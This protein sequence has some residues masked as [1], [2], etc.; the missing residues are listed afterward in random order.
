MSITIKSGGLAVMDPSDVRVFTFDWDA[1]NLSTAVTIT[2]SSWTITTTQQNGL[3]VLT[4]DNESIL[5]G[6]RRTQVRLN[7]T[8]AT[9]GDAYL[10]SNKIVTNESPTQT[11]EQS[12]QVVI[13]N[14]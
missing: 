8:T 13:Q 11:K 9:V 7:A 12:F 6:S 5:S 4:K 10:V 2:T 1:N 14:R 3:T